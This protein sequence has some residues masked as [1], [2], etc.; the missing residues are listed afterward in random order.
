MS[1][2][3][4]TTVSAIFVDRT[5]FTDHCQLGYSS[6]TSSCGKNLSL[7]EV[8]ISTKERKKISQI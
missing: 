5:E 7:P 6:E 4:V 1:R 2:M 8:S 3:F